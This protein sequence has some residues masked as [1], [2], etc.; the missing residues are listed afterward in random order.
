MY[1]ALGSIE[2]SHGQIELAMTYFVKAIGL[3][4]EVG[5][6]DRAIADVKFN[7]AGAQFRLGKFEESMTTHG[8]ALDIYRQVVGDGKNP[9]VVDNA[10]LKDVGLDTGVGTESDEV[11]NAENENAFRTQLV[12]MDALQQNLANMTAKDEL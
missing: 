9:L 10:L 6:E 4:E 7:M 12:N 5:G 11:R 1:A 2:L 8:E 3:Y